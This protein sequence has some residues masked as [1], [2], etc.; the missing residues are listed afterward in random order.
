MR[1]DLVRA[2]GVGVGL[3]PIP[4][5]AGRPARG[6]ARR[7]QGRAYPRGCGATISIAHSSHR[8][9][10]LSPRVRGDLS[11][12]KV[13]H[14]NHGPIPAGAG[15][16]PPG[17]R[18]PFG[19]AAYPRGCG[20]PFPILVQLAEHGAFPRGC[21]ATAI[22]S[23][24]LWWVP[25]LS[26]RVRGDR[27]NSR[28]VV[29]LPGPIPAGAGRPAGPGSGTP[30]W[31]AYP[32]GCGA[33][34]SSPLVSPRVVGLSPRVRGDH[35]RPHGRV[36]VVRPIPAGAGR[37]GLSGQLAVAEG[38]YPRGCGATRGPIRAPRHLGGLSPR[39][40]GDRRAAQVHR[41]LLGPIPAG[42][43]RPRHGHARPA[44][45]RAYPR[46]CGATSPAPTL[47]PS[48]TGL[49]PRVRGDRGSFGD[50]RLGLRPIPAG[51]GRPPL[52]NVA[53]WCFKAY[54][55]GCG[56]T[57]FWSGGS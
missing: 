9:G 28:I 36:F 53:R 42:A 54:P 50:G 48:T 56:A 32:R 14:A 30:G 44:G 41:P 25:G 52:S 16:P 17:H 29:L 24:L 49:S 5:G 38:A 35:G 4:A 51:A 33:T 2:L 22:D 18:Q 7:R 21:G 27:A 57:P 46:G 1:G 34:E 15:R 45:R 8:C 3:G 39:V 43:G 12:T 31:R 47:K 26:P 37:P 19:G 55:R 23:D 13:E 6:T 11:R 10:G 20:R 40:R